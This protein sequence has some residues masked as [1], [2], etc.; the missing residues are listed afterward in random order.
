MGLPGRPEIAEEIAVASNVKLAA[1]AE[2][3]LHLTGISTEASVKLVKE[4]R[5]KKV[6]ITCSVTPYNLVFCDEDVTTYDS[7][8]KVN[9]PLRNKKTAKRC[10][11]L[12]QKEASIVLHLIIFLT[13]KIIKWWNLNMLKMV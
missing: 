8:L 7:N 5:Q 6:A 1:Y 3:N 12:L 4:A 2:S 13:T 11:K 9:P 10:K